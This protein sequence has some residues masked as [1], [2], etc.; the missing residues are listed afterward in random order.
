[1]KR[2]FICT[3]DAI[4]SCDSAPP[5]EKHTLYK[6]KWRSKAPLI[7]INNQ[8]VLFISKAYFNSESHKI[9]LN[10]NVHTF[11]HRHNF[12]FKSLTEN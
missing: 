11:S 5:F 12:K 10:Q 4:Y 3:W 9:S 2:V 1:M 6:A 7:I 8:F